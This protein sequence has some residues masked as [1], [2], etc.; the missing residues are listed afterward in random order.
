LGLQRCQAL[1]QKQPVGSSAK[2]RNAT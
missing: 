2:N 1:C